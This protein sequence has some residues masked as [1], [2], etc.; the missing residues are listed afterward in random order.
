MET[1]ENYIR[2]DKAVKETIARLPAPHR[3]L[4]KGYD[5]RFEPGNTLKDDPGHVG[6]VYIGGKDKTITIS[7]PWNYGREFTLLHEVAHFVYNKF[8]IKTKWEAAWYKIYKAESGPK[9]EGAEEAFC[10]SYAAFYCK[11]PPEKFCIKSWRKFME[12]FSKEFV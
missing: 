2:E 8:V 10:H 5:I 1:F 11:S 12:E 4:V 3:A 9:K 6:R 7:S